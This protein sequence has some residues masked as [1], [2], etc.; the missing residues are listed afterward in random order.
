MRSCV[1]WCLSICKPLRV[2]QHALNTG[3]ITGEVYCH[4]HYVMYKTIWPVLTLAFPTLTQRCIRPPSLYHVTHLTQA[5]FRKTCLI[6]A[7]VEHNCV[8]HCLPWLDDHV[9]RCWWF[10]SY[11]VCGLNR[12]CVSHTCANQRSACCCRSMCIFKPTE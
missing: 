7:C 6:P 9:W 4:H 11:R 2:N 3:A 10:V 5:A 1:G 8:V 12:T